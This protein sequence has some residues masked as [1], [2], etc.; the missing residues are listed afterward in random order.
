MSAIQIV[1]LSGSL[2]AA[3]TNTALLHAVAASAPAGVSVEIL[4]LGQILLF[5]PDLDASPP[6]PMT[7]LRA[8]VGDADGLIIANPEYALGIS[9]GLKNALDWLVGY[10]GFSRTPVQI[11]NVAP[12]AHHSVAARCE[13]LVTIAA[14]PIHEHQ[15]ALF[16]LNDV[17]RY[18]QTMTV[19][20]AYK[21]TK[22]SKRKPKAIRN[23]L[24]RRQSGRGVCCRSMSR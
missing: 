6:E 13:V 16:L 3:S 21:T 18:W 24:R 8:K 20:Y 23:V 14:W 5:N 11:L 7:S 4:P 9:D 2:R 17:I 12:R 15:L 19:D 1:A 10:E 22:F